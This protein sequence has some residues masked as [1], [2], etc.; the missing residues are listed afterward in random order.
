MRSSQPLHAIRVLV[1]DSSAIHCELLAESIRRDRRFAVAGSASTSGDIQSLLRENCPDVLLISASMDEQPYGGLHLLAELRSTHPDIKAV[2]LLESPKRETVVQAFRV[3]ARGVFSKK[4]P[5]KLLGKCIDC[6]HDGQVWATTEELGFVL[7]ALAASPVHP[8]GSISLSQL[9]AREL[10]V[11]TCLA[12]GLSNA[13]I[14][15]RLKLSRH[16]VKNYMFKVFDK[17]GVSSRV[18]LLFHVLSCP[19]SELRGGD[20]GGKHAVLPFQTSSR[21]LKEMK[22]HAVSEP[23]GRRRAAVRGKETPNDESALL[24]VL[25]KLIVATERRADAVAAGADKKD[26]NGQDPATA[27]RPSALLARLASSA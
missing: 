25:G 2:V 27:S 14:A 26:S 17:L 13:E 20:N 24:T 7:E 11:V 10:D 9:S 6:V 8:L 1:A 21:Q 18:E 22:E 19:P 4:S 12:E 15:E 3:G 16:T 5:F 23:R